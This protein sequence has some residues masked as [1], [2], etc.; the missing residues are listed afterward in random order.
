MTKTIKNKVS[1]NWYGKRNSQWKLGPNQD[2][3]IIP[4]GSRTCVIVKHN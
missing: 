1:C 2:L 3:Q 4:V